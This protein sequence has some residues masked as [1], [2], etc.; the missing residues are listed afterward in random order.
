MTGS[1]ALVPA[2]VPPARRARG[3]RPGRF[4]ASGGRLVAGLVAAALA[5]GACGADGSP[6]D[7]PERDRDG[8]GDGGG[9]GARTGAAGADEPAVV[10]TAE[11]RGSFSVPCDH[12]HSAPDDPIVHAGHQGAS[13]RHDFFGATTTDAA[14][15]PASLQAGGTT[16]RSVADRSAYWAPT[17]RA[18]GRP[19][20]PTHV[21]AYYR[22]PVGADAHRLRPP[23]N[24]L[25]MIAGDAAA[26]RDQDPRVV[27][28][29]C[30]LPED[31]SPVPQRCA[32]GGAELRLVLVF[33][34]CWDGERLRSADHVSHLA[35]LPGTDVEREAGGARCPASHPVLLP[36]ITV[37]VRYPTELPPG[38]LTLAS[39][40]AT[41]GHGDVLVAWDEDDLASEVDTCLR[42]NLRCD[43]VS[44]PRRLGTGPT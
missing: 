21:L 43:V 6:A 5:F 4:G 30:G 7:R 29:S 44:E 32:V 39:G 22:T 10:A 23:P 8:D 41:G 34:T 42:R 20:T 3:R 25:E 37:E 19:V 17:L 33:P 26:P 40:P 28:W 13:H 14:S 15:T 12:S 36:E 11:A 16:C 27:R 35:Y 2:P 18:G 31:A 1:A 9:R 38:E 24:G